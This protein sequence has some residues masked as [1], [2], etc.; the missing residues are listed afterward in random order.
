M[1]VMLRQLTEGWI[2]WQTFTN[3][4]VDE[5]VL[6]RKVRIKLWR[7]QLGRAWAA[8]KAD[9]ILVHEGQQHMS[10]A[11]LHWALGPFLGAFI[12]WRET[13]SVA[14]ELMTLEDRASDYLQHREIASSWQRWRHMSWWQTQLM[15]DQKRLFERWRRCMEAEFYE[16]ST[17]HWA[18]THYRIFWLRQVFCFWR[19]W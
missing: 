15:L 12:T 3:V 2:M 10:Q 13:A 19:P 11:V 17:V 1:H 9:A 7:T 4:T 16:K 5:Y 6:V 14:E 8:W 18:T